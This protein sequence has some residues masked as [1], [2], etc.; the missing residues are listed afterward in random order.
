MIGRERHR[1]QAARRLLRDVSG[2]RGGGFD[3]DSI[4]VAIRFGT[5]E[6]DDPALLYNDYTETWLQ[7]LR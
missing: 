3:D 5:V 6:S 7:L 2:H 1:Q 4:D